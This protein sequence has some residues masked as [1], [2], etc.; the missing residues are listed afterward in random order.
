LSPPGRSSVAGESTHPLLPDTPQLSVPASFPPNRRLWSLDGRCCSRDWSRGSGRPKRTSGF[1][2]WSHVGHRT[3]K[4]CREVRGQDCTRR[5]SLGEVVVMWKDLPVPRAALAPPP[6]P[7]CR[8][9]QVLAATHSREA[10]PVSHLAN[11]DVTWGDP[12][13]VRLVLFLYSDPVLVQPD[14]TAK[15][16]IIV[17][18]L[19]C[20][21]CSRVRTLTSRRWWVVCPLS[22]RSTEEEDR[23]TLRVQREQGNCWA[24]ISSA[25]VGRT[26]HAV[27]VRTLGPSGLST[28]A[29]HARLCCLCRPNR[30]RREPSSYT[31]NN[32]QSRSTLPPQQVTHDLAR[33]TRSPRPPL[34]PP[35][36]AG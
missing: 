3:S 36:P 28:Q 6:Q 34:V 8:Q 31:T 24:E 12:R 18:V 15:R 13:T 16:G 21:W 4:Q 14:R 5:G 19:G 25:L 2:A 1:G 30:C 27:K 10:L 11:E 9:R 22:G 17:V 26:A 7:Q 20:W 33:L 29:A 32:H 23:T 35:S